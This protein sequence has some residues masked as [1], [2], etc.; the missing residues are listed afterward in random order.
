MESSGDL[1][2]FRCGAGGTYVAYLGFVSGIASGKLIMT[3]N[4]SLA[5]RLFW[6]GAT[7]M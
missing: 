6:A 7:G 2:V 4:A 5:Y 1:D 3:Y